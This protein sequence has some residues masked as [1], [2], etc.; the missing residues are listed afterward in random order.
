MGKLRWFGFT[1]VM[2]GVVGCDHA[3]KHLATEN[4]SQPVSLVRGLVDLRLAH[5]TDTAFSLLGGV[6]GADMRWYVITL[7]SLLATL[8]MCFLAFRH[9]QRL[10]VAGR[11]AAALVLGG[12][13]GN[14][15]DRALR[16]H[17]VDFIH[18][19]YWPIFNVADVAIVL[20]AALLLLAQPARAAPI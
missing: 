19:S 4:L 10:N 17:V 9:W 3:T 6:L 11:F 7:V 1:L 13:L 2:S 5:N 20:G 16:G 18:V 14:V 15:T 12:A 8:G